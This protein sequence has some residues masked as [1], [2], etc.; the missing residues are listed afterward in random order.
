MAS[1][2]HALQDEMKDLVARHKQL[3]K[4]VDTIYNLEK[5]LRERCI[6]VMRCI[7]NILV[8]VTFPFYFDGNMIGCPTLNVKITSY[9]IFHE[10]LQARDWSKH[11]EPEL[12]HDS[13]DDKIPLSQMKRFIEV[14]EQVRQERHGLSM[15]FKMN[16]L[17][18]K[19]VEK[20]HFKTQSFVVH[21]CIAGNLSSFLQTQ[22][23]FSVQ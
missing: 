12:A 1:R 19:R 22:L 5:E 3:K 10:N 16:D 14:V 9:R 15:V 18:L 6:S 11:R 8:P 2:L 4:E 13:F 20:H 23:I 17:I 21:L 7:I